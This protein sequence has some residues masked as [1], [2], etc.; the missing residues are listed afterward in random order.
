MW[1]IVDKFYST[2]AVGSSNSGKT[3]GY[4]VPLLKNLTSFKGYPQPPDESPLCVILCPSWRVVVE[5][6]AALKSMSQDLVVPSDTV[7]TDKM[8]KKLKI[9]A[10]F[11]KE[12]EQRKVVALLSGCHVLIT[13]P[14]SLVRIITAEHPATHLGRCCHLI[15]EN[16]DETLDRFPEDVAVIMKVFKLVVERRKKKMDTQVVV[17][18][19]W[20]NDQLKYFVDL[21]LKPEEDHVG[22]F[23]V[24][25]DVREAFIYGRMKVETRFLENSSEKLNLL[26]SLLPQAT[27]KTVILCS[28]VDAANTIKV[29]MEHNMPSFRI[30]VLSEQSSGSIKESMDL[31][32]VW[33]SEAK[34]GA[35]TVAIISDLYFPDP[36]GLKASDLVIHFDLSESVSTFKS[37][38]VHMKD[39][40]VSYY[41]GEQV[42]SSATRCY[43]LPTKEDTAKL[44]TIYAFLKRASSNI[45][46]DL[47]Q[48][49]LES[50]AEAAANKT[51]SQLCSNVKIF[52]FCWNKRMCPD[53][54]FFI[55]KDLKGPIDVPDDSAIKVVEY[56]IVEVKSACEFFVRLISLKTT[57]NRL[58]QDFS[59]SYLKLAFK[60]LAV[61]Q[62]LL[63]RV[64][65][66]YD[67]VPKGVFLFKDS[68]KCW[69]RV[70][71]QP[72]RKDELEIRMI[73]D[74]HSVV[75]K[76]E[77]V[78]LY[79]VPQDIAEFP[80]HSMDIILTGLTPKDKDVEWP[81]E[82]CEFVETHSNG[83]PEMPGEED[84]E[85]LCRS[86]PLVILGS[87]AWVKQAQVLQ[88]LEK[89]AVDG[90]T[91]TRTW[92]VVFE[93][94]E[95][96]LKKN[97]ADVNPVHGTKLMELCMAANFSVHR[98]LNLQKFCGSVE[99][100]T[101]NLSDHTVTA[102]AE[103][104][105]ISESKPTEN[106]ILDAGIRKLYHEAKQ[107]VVNDCQRAHL[108]DNR[109]EEVK[110]TCV[111]DPGYFFVR[112]AKFF[113]Q[114]NQLESELFEFAEESKSFY[115]RSDFHPNVGRLCIGRISQGTKMDANNIEDSHETFAYKRIQIQ[116]VAVKADFA[117]SFDDFDSEEDEEEEELLVDVKTFVAFFVDYG[118]SRV[119]SELDLVPL[120]KKFI[121]RLPM[122]AIECRLDNV[123][124]LNAGAWD[125]E[126]IK[127]VK[128]LAMY[129]EDTFPEPNLRASCVELQSLQVA[130]SQN[131]E[132][133]KVYSVLMFH[134]HTRLPLQAELTEKGLAEIVDQDGVD[135]ANMG[136]NN[137]D[138]SFEYV[139]DTPDFRLNKDNM[140]EFQN[141][142]PKES[143]KQPNEAADSVPAP[144]PAP[145]PAPTP[146]RV[147][148]K[149]LH[150]V[151]PSDMPGIAIGDNYA[152]VIRKSPR[153]V[154][155][156]QDSKK[157]TTTF[158][159]VID[160][161][162][163][164]QLILS[165]CFISVTYET[166]EMEYLDVICYEDGREDYAF[167]SIPKLW[168][169]GAVHPDKT[170][171]RCRG[172]T[173][174]VELTKQRATFWRKPAVDPKTGKPIK[175]QWIKPDLQNVSDSED[176]EV[177][178]EQR[179]KIADM[180]PAPKP[181]A[182]V[183]NY[184]ELSSE[185]SKS[186]DE[187]DLMKVGLSKLHE[188]YLNEAPP[189]IHDPDVVPI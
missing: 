103:M 170:K 177:K 66:T 62:D 101:R 80:R 87:V 181:T 100:T 39:S 134:P 48:F 155:W 132:N 7:E 173:L 74:G 89:L 64:P 117:Q 115:S 12:H 119:L 47:K 186:S 24:F 157:S 156:S 96:L 183:K 78:L 17:T 189:L 178:K 175:L 84:R 29:F 71:V 38:F 5:T 148:E 16:V 31:I 30:F 153:E 131:N 73:D 53:R 137:E 172:N 1:P 187:I 105:K 112:H 161:E 142:E 70:E 34:K 95:E 107:T 126:A 91:W 50:Q 41:D 94:K 160:P 79:E 130:E 55:S 76:V 124:P 75:K 25:A 58:V 106:K 68:D 165:N 168:L 166:L 163:E 13:T 113:K 65:L 174:I 108:S 143:K 6:E 51:G 43:I 185:S 83:L 88:K 10:I 159:F 46:A 22:P 15:L 104:S 120:P 82:P 67:D 102:I 40:F 27:G 19:R 42:E 138:E 182:F 11:E 54:H 179:K 188:L 129:H 86:S 176:E 116:R 45:P 140:I 26:P 110:V 141:N 93:A 146:V 81:A 121:D 167:Y 72:K 9:L 69:K 49:F 18:S 60:L 118:F 122:Q 59:K 139:G 21:Y 145:A 52:G 135:Y 171:V 151:Y 123:E 8:P 36:L 149:Y 3:I 169:C 154:I 44:K 63:E 99:D 128:S 114:L 14:P 150:P 32:P 152:A 133:S 164:T 2:V 92:S 20:W 56:K 111:Y 98:F 37:R 127:I 162:V 61:K 125:A 33:K 28:N 97:L 57:G 158:K 4:L 144:A 109:L 85:V 77:D 180:F 35:K 147:P 23:F 184:D 136:A 90:E